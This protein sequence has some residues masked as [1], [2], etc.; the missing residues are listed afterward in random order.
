MLNA[1]CFASHFRLGSPVVSSRGAISGVR[2]C[3]GL[4]LMGLFS[5]PA[6]ANDEVNSIRATVST[7]IDATAY[8]EADRLREIFHEEAKLYLDHKD[9][10]VF[11]MESP[12]FVEAFARGKKGEFN[13]RYGSVLHINRSGG[14]ATAKAEIIIPA[15]KS[16]FVDYF[17]L[18]KIEGRWMITGK[19]AVREETDMTGASAVI[20][21]R[22]G[23]GFKGIERAYRRL[24]AKGLMVEFSESSSEPCPARKGG[25]ED[26]F[27][28]A[29]P[30]PH[31]LFSVRHPSPRS[32]L[33]GRE[34]E[35]RVVIGC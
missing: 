8:S 13:G 16:R 25:N 15:D 22:R 19:S 21:F 12:K 27:G 4:A 6:N 26:A 2:V 32:M 28:A 14:T 29:F 18:K 34:F 35:E 1:R 23:S 7:Y 31:V 5:I 24:R 9:C 17:L 10:P 11:V 20:E 33:E 3:V 30:D